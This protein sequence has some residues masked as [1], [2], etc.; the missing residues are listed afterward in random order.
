MNYLT[1][2]L[3]VTP[4]NFGL[5]LT[6]YFAHF[7][8]GM[9]AVLQGGLLPYI[10]AEYG[11]SYAQSGLLLSSHQI[12][13]L[14]AVLLMGILPFLIGK[15]KSVLFLGPGVI[16]G[17]IL[18]TVTGNPIILIIAFSLTG[19][20]R[21]TMSNSN[22]SEVSKI[23]SNRASALSLLNAFFA[24]GALLAPLLLA[25]GENTS[26]GWRTAPFVLSITAL[27]A[28]V[29]LARSGLSNTQAIKTASNSFTFLKT[30][31]FWLNAGVLFCYL[32]AEATIIG[33]FQLY[34]AETE[35][36]PANIANITPSL[37]WVM[38]L[39]GRIACAA[40]PQRVNKNKLS[41]MLGIIFSVMFVVIIT[42]TSSIVGIICLTIIGLSMA[43][44]YPLT[45]AVTHNT[46][47]TTVTGTLM[48]IAIIG[49]IT[50]PGF[51]GVL[52]DNYGLTLGLS[53]VIVPLAIMI[54]LL[55][56]KNIYNKQT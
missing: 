7:N 13:N 12:G 53:A 14:G 38:I 52:A 37:L 27:A 5:L 23:A 26:I 24:F 29:L 43:G 47:S 55:I 42:T 51:V 46:S 48:A 2:K 19:I 21:G 6:V 44:M 32:A 9:I 16:V 8:N 1:R 50:M 54:I 36:L 31:N 39:L 18:T 25:F 45:I 40:I 30:T 41:L 17:F 11:L 56:T 33:W 28:F 22:T 4:I 34:F 20:C 49:A 35:L 10:R 15:K 3:G